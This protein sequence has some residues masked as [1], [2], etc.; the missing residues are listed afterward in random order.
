M[1]VANAP[2]YYIKGFIVQPPEPKVMNILRV[3][4]VGVLQ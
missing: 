4:I 2:S 1:A 3:V